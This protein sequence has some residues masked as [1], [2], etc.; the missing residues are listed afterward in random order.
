M[1]QAWAD[2]VDDALQRGYEARQQKV[3]AQVAD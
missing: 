1:M 3:L 2:Y